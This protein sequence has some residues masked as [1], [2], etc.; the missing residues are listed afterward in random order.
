M[1]VALFKLPFDSKIQILARFARY[2]M[3]IGNGNKETAYRLSV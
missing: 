2:D 3:I 1:N